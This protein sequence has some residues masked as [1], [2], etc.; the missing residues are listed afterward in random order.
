[1][2][3]PKHPKNALAKEKEPDPQ[4]VRVEYS[5]LSSYFST[6]VQF[7]FT[8]LGFFI[9]AIG[10]ILSGD[11]TK[12]KALLLLFITLALY[13]IEL[14]NRTLYNN[15]S[16]RAM[17]IERHCWG[18]KGS[19]AYDPFYSHMMKVRPTDD[20]DAPEPPEL[21][22]PTISNRSEIIPIRVS[23]GRGLDILYAAVAIFAILQ[24]YIAPA[25]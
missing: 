5:A 21:D 16:D 1:M 11:I 13:M 24:V 18:Y 9:A 17:Q 2:E 4:D 25:W 6:V 3:N 12:S 15:L 23:H 10:F 22:Y 19:K 7:R 8:T 14:R 20:P